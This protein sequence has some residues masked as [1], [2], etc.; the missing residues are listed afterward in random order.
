MAISVIQVYVIST[1]SM[2]MCKT[3]DI[4]K[5]EQSMK[6]KAMSRPVTFEP[7]IEY[8]LQG[9]GYQVTQ[10]LN[11][12]TLVARNL[13][14]NTHV[15]QR[16]DLLWQYWL[17]NILQFACEGPNLR[18]IAGTILKTTYTF[19]DLADLPSHLQEIT[20]H[21]YQL[22][23]PLVHLPSRQRTKQVVEERIRTYL[24]SLEKEKARGEHGYLF[25]LHVG[26]RTSPSQRDDQY[27]EGQLDRAQ[28]D[29]PSP[30]D[31]SEGDN[32][33]HSH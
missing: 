1:S 24:S 13:A 20:W 15:S 7:G 17:D 23:R 9:V 12:G 31:R 8:V 6:G 26:R 4:V 30:L 22:I 29:D 25:G 33:T 14:T 28:A 10:V 32:E 11:D 21:R 2:E 3:S 5:H 19:A 27:A 18:D 16:L